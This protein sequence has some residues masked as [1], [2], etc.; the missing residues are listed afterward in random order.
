ML[1]RP[2]QLDLRR[3]RSSRGIFAPVLRHAHGRFHLVTTH[4]DG[5]G[6]FLVTARRPQGP[7]SDPVWIDPHGIDPSLLDG[8]DVY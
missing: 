1:T 4:V 2:G 3:T 7:W 5:G 8:R 6:N